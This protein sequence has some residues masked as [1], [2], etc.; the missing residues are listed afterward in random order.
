MNTESKTDENATVGTAPET[1]EPTE[2]V[3]ITLDHIRE[4]NEKREARNMLNLTAFDKAADF[5]KGICKELTGPETVRVMTGVAMA[6]SEHAYEGD[7]EMSSQAVLNMA[8][9]SAD[10]TEDVMRED[11]RRSRAPASMLDMLVGLAPPPKKPAPPE[12]GPL[13]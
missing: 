12:T 4:Q 8:Q 13:N 7:R 3:K 5:C 1:E 11:R 2:G 9:I 10:E 6:V